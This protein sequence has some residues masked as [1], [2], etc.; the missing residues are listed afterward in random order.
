MKTGDMA[1]TR[2][3]MTP[4]RRLQSASQSI[5]F[6]FRF[7]FHFS[8]FVLFQ[9]SPNGACTKGFLLALYETGPRRRTCAAIAACT[10]M[11]SDGRSRGRSTFAF[12]APWT[13][14]TLCATVA[15]WTCMNPF[16]RRRLDYRGLNPLWAGR[17][18]EALLPP[19]SL[20]PLKD[21]CSVRCS[22]C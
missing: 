20:G 22:A 4:G 7:V 18:V 11:D 12:V 13:L 21:L 16:C 19:S 6:R 3:R 5:F 17:K 2:K 14:S 15:A 9:V 8:F 10:P 1:P